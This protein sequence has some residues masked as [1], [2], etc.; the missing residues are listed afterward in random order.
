MGI[1]PGS[2]ALAASAARE[3]RQRLAS[4]RRSEA[5]PRLAAPKR[6]PGCA[7]R[8]EGRG[9][10]KAGWC[11]WAE[12]DAG[13]CRADADAASSSSTPTQSS[14]ARGRGEPSGRWSIERRTARDEG[15]RRGGEGPTSANVA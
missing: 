15:A 14:R 9:G 3:A 11:V 10:G 2:R 4:L 5:A 8:G 6:G 1:T 7:R 13:A 12:E